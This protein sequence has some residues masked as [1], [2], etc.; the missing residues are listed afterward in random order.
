M[1]DALTVL[2]EAE[3]V[4]VVDWPAPEVPESLVRAGFT[5][6]VKGGPGPRDYSVRELRDGDV[7][8]R[9]LGDRP[10]RVDLVYAYRPLS[11]LPGIVAIGKELGARALWWQAGPSGPEP[12]DSR[13][14][15]QIAGEAGL[16]YVDDVFIV[17]AVHELEHQ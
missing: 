6:F 12:D 14:A 2:R 3:T 13:R 17:D 9:P 15:R 16:A 11:E 1:S 4:V 5:V 7:V 10:E 8:S